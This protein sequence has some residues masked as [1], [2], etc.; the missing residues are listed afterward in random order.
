[1]KN[2]QKRSSLPELMALLVFAVFA[3]CILLVLLTG[4]DVYRKLTQR[5]QQSFDRRTVCQYLT[6]RVRQADQE[7][8]VTVE[9]F[10][11]Q[12]AL[13]IREVIADKT[14]LTRIYCYEGTL[15]ELYTPNSG[16]FSPEDGEVLLDAEGLSL[17]M[18]GAT[19]HARIRFADD[20]V[21]LLTLRLRSLQGGGL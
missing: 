20:T 7:N 2:E 11:G 15:R 19:L 8:A 17:S 4:G 10:C 14:Y 18:E 5:D 1:M 16:D 3:V 9:A 6:T 21:R 12:D 13:V